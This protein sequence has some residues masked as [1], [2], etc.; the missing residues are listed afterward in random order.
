MPDQGSSWSYL[1]KKTHNNLHVSSKIKVAA[2]LVPPNCPINARVLS[3]GLRLS[4]FSEVSY[5]T[6]FN[7]W[8]VMGNIFPVMYDGLKN[9]SVKRYRYPHTPPFATLYTRQFLTYVFISF[10][11]SCTRTKKQNKFKRYYRGV[12]ACTHG[13]HVRTWKSRAQKGYRMNK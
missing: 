5:C 9:V 11:F 2:R 13:T 12:A 10:G 3:L 8:C 7:M 1:C 4:L 6:S